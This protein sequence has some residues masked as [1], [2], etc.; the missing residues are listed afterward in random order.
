VDQ[1][2]RLRLPCDGGVVLCNRGF[3][4]IDVLV[5]DA[6]VDGGVDN[7][8]T[9]EQFTDFI[10]SLLTQVDTPSGAPLPPPEH[11]SRASARAKRVGRRP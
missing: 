2:D 6:L 1:P 11:A 8:D 3:N 9:V 10:D 5:E 4:P 7:G